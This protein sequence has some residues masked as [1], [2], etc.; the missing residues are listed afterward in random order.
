VSPATETA[1]WTHIDRVDGSSL[2]FERWRIACKV[3]WLILDSGSGSLH[4]HTFVQQTLS[5]L[6]R[7]WPVAFSLHGS[8]GMLDGM[9]WRDFVHSAPH[10]RY[11]DL[12]LASDGKAEDKITWAGMQLPVLSQLPL[13]ALR[14]CHVR[15]A[16]I[17]SMGVGMPSQTNSPPPP[18]HPRLSSTMLDLAAD[19]AGYI[20]S[21][22]VVSVG[23]GLRVFDAE[24]L[25]HQFRGPAL[26][27]RIT[28]NHESSSANVDCRTDTEGDVSYG[29]SDGDST[30]GEERF[31]LNPNLA[32]T[33]GPNASRRMIPISRNLGE[34]IRAY[35]ESS[36]FTETSAFDD[37]LFEQLARTVVPYEVV[38]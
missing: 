25:R 37:E 32:K 16:D 24:L 18:Q 19:I 30:Q 35:M 38:S 1:S 3:R 26:W 36:K 20:P 17:H 4:S 21:L 14:L 23:E 11:L 8:P 33:L 6:Q 2:D 28:P 12:T 27:W 10:I 15:H 5:I 29:S 13:V 34:H 31:D 22:N 9:C 7:T